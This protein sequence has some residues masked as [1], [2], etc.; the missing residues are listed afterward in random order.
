M[1]LYCFE[2]FVQESLFRKSC[3]KKYFIWL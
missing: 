2:K 3:F 1:F